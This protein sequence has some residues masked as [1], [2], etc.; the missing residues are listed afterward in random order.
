MKSSDNKYVGL[1]WKDGGRD[2]HGVDCVGLAALWLKEHHGFEVPPPDSQ[3]D[4]EATEILKGRT[5]DAAKLERGDVVFFA[6]KAGTI[7]HVAIWLG[8][9]KNLHIVKGFAARV[10]TGFRLHQRC[11]NHPVAALKPHEAEL[12]AKVLADG[13]VRWEFAIMAVISIALSVISALLMPRLAR[14]G[15]KYGRYGF[16]SLI[17]QTSTEIPLPDL[18]GAVVVAGNSPYTQPSDKSLSATATSQ[19]ANRVVVFASGP[20]E[21]VDFELVGIKI[22]GLS[23]TDAYFRNGSKI[24]GFIYDPEQTKAMACDGTFDSDT[25]VPSLTFYDGTHDISVPVDVRADYDRN[26]P[27]YGFSGCCYAVFRLI[28][29]SKFSQLNITTKLKGRKFRTFDADGFIETTVTSEAVGTGDASTRRFKLDFDDIKSVSAVTVNGVSWTEL[30]ASNQTGNVFAVNRLK[31]FLEFPDNIPGSTHAIVATYIY[32]PRIW[33]Q[34]PASHL[35]YLLTEI[36]RGNG[37]DASKINFETFVEAADYFDETV[38]WVNSNGV[39]SGPR[40][41]TNYAVDFRKPIQEH[42]RALLDACRSVIFVSGGQFVLKPIQADASVFSFDTSNIV[43]DSFSSLL[44]DRAE[45]PN[46]IKAFYHSSDTYQAETEAVREDTAD[47]FAR[48]TRA[49]N[50]G[51]VEENLKFPAV[52]N[53]SQA[54]R[55]AEIYLRSQINSRW[56][57]SLKTTVQGLALEVGDVVD[58]THPSQ[59]TWAAKLFRVEDTKLD[60]DDRLELQLS[61]YF[62]GLEV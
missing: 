46:R 61:E 40:Y 14:S 47:Q 22:N 24:D 13:A 36:G 54:E 34:N 52:D 23:Y 3:Q 38:D 5:F 39:T 30:S 28:D 9:G 59:P 16:D 1:P 60:E 26:F 20:V 25:Y 10:D 37:Y 32:Y 15:N 56:R 29:S 55:L 51:V 7:R 21:G 12:L 43:K 49:G 19:R 48:E 53:Q 11:G 58:I 45:A 50:G 2:F 42:M 31:G 27:V 33:T 8:D 44:V 17:T 4:G 41:T 62:A 35:L 6:N 18:L 57:C